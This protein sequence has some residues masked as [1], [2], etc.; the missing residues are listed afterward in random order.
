MSGGRME[1]GGALLEY[2]RM[3]AR[4]QQRALDHI[5]TIRREGAPAQ[6]LDAAIE[7][8]A[9]ATSMPC[10]QVRDLVGS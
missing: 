3:Q 9:L 7:V 5:R 6:V 1:E 4:H 10:A 8:Y 2:L